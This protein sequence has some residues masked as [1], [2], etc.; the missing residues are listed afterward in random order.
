MAPPSPQPETNFD[1]LIIGAGISGIN[2]AY[3]L[4][5]QLP[6]HTYC[7]LE[8][9]HGI[10][11]T[12]DFFKYPGI[13]SDSDL[14]T[15][16]FPWKPWAEQKSIADGESIA[17]YIRETAK[18]EGIDK[19]VRFGEKLREASWS[20]EQQRW[21]LEV[22]VDDPFAD[23]ND[24]NSEKPATSSQK[25]TYHARFL[26]LATGYYDYDEAL[27]ATIPN[28][29]SFRGTTVHPQFW[30]S[31]IDY[32]DK[33]V[34][35]VGSG[36]TAVTLL[37]SLAA[38]AKHVTMLQR[39]PGYLITIPQEKPGDSWLY[40]LL[41]TWAYLKLQRLK[42]LIFPYLFFLFCRTFPSAARS[43]LRKGTLAQLP[44]NIPHDPHFVPIYNPWEQRL[45]ACPDGDFFTALH[46]GKASIA[47]GHVDTVTADSILLKS[48]ERIPADIIV[49]ATGLKVR[50]A[51]GAKISVDGEPVIVGEKFMWK[52]V[53]L[54]DIPNA[55]MVV[56]YTN[57]SWTLGADATALH[58]CRLLKHMEATGFSSVVPRLSPSSGGAGEWEGI[59]EMPLLNLSS[60]YI[61]KAKGEFPKAG[62][63]GPWKARGNYFRDLWEAKRGD[64]RTGLEFERVS[65]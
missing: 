61:T 20:S 42:F 17:R 25:R 55:A 63:R 62:D 23:N 47:T 58:I 60:T 53:M 3:R 49:T 30:P 16:G 13:R 15:F 1:T 54:Q 52:G 38:T 33:N 56:G 24:V 40:P 39:S 50:I 36:A 8:S 21:R 5:T 4:Q 22:D 6:H 14:H 29:S 11:G 65:V 26:L 59:K 31:D 41:P 34:V 28:I 51:G 64:I 46:A 35:I 12:W 19:H 10:G 2:F 18:G 27:P 57:A 45:C 9:R 44:K 32:T 37:P 7:I 43:V 48:G